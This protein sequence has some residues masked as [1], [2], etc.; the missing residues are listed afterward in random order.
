M[1]CGIC[2]GDRFDHGL[3][4]RSIISLY[5]G[6]LRSSG[7][8]GCGQKI[9]ETMRAYALTQQTNS[10][11][12]R[13]T[14][15]NPSYQRDARAQRYGMLATPTVPNLYP[16][17]PYTPLTHTEE[18]L[19]Q[20]VKNLPLHTLESLLNT[21]PYHTTQDIE[22]LNNEIIYKAQDIQGR[23][24]AVEAKI[25]ALKEKQAA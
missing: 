14:M 1:S 6:G 10:N 25:H 21:L 12:G 19:E 2:P 17:K 9:S 13:T 3:S 23:R 15:K 11:Y 16:S 22:T 24:K 5:T 4:M 20:R 18:K 8:G 7:Y